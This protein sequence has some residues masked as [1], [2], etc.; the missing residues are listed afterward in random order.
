MKEGLDILYALQQKDDQLKE[1]ATVIQEI[2]LQIKALEDE[3]DSRSEMIENAKKKLQANIDERKKFE[4]DI[5]AIKEKIVKY[6]EQMKKVT[7]NKEYQGISN[8]IK[9]EEAN[10]TAV[11]EKIIEKMVGADE[12]MGVI[13]ETEREFNQIAA[14]YNQKIK[15]LHDYL[16]YHKN[17]L[18]EETKNK[19][20]LRSQV[21][22]NLL[23]AYDNLFAK[24]AGKV[25]SFVQTDFCGVC[26]IKIRPQVLSELV[27]SNDVL[28]CESCGRILFK[29]IAGEDEE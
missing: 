19:K 28:I 17:K 5:A 21:A 23:K 16:E 14:E 24:K 4:R 3:R 18:S 22:A 10:I 2:P 26:N 8:E 25:V 9:F 20:E 29:K 12:I 7:T 11:E 1:I 27:L 15:E 6:K 13:R